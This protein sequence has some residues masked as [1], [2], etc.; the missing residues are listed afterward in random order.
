[1]SSREKYPHENELFLAV[2]G[3]I[4]EWLRYG[5]DIG[6]GGL[7]SLKAS[8]DEVSGEP[9][10]SNSEESLEQIR[11]DL[12]NCVLCRLHKERS[13]IV[14]GT[15]NPKAEL[16]FVGE[17]PGRDEDLQGEPFVGKA[18]QLLTRIIEA[19]GYRRN[20]VYITNVVKCRPPDNRNPEENEVAL[21]IPYLFRQIRAIKPKVI[22]ALGSVAAHALLKTKA[23][24]S[25]MRGRFYDFQGIPLMPTYHP[26]FLLRNP[27]KK[28]E[29]WE[30]IKKIMSLLGK[31]LSP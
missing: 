1:M 30:D 16:M 18:G 6:I 21:C 29:V 9:L 11:R 28:R 7:F 12:E 4:K 5:T 13:R 8:P 2:L 10:P 15:G 14:F 17:A 24:I 22:C 20:D 26:A 27:H 25:E 23:P 3:E 19:M 31:P